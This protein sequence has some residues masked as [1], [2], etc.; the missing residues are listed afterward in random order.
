MEDLKYDKFIDEIKAMINTKRDLIESREETKKS[1]KNGS[2]Y[3]H[4]RK[5]NPVPSEMQAGADR[6]VQLISELEELDK[7]ITDI[8]II[9]VSK[10]EVY[11]SNFGIKFDTIEKLNDAGDFS[12]KE[13]VYAGF[14]NLKD[15]DMITVMPDDIWF[16]KLIKEAYRPNNISFVHKNF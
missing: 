15:E 4:K 3:F 10:L 13:T 14:P 12:K 16:L 11:T 2:D 6:M 8:D 5:L 7:K 1:I 9:I